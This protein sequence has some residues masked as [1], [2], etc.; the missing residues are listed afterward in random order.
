M[1]RY[2]D[3]G[4]AVNWASPLNRGLVSWWMALP[5]QQRGLYFRD[6]CGRNHGTLTNGP[7]WQGAMGR[8]GGSGAID[9]GG[10]A[11]SQSVVVSSSASLP[12]T[13][14]TVSAWVSAD[15]WETTAGQY[16]GI[17]FRRVAGSNNGW[18]IG[19]NGDSDYVEFTTHDG[20]F[21]SANVGYSAAGLSAGNWN[22]LCGTCDATNVTLYINGVQKAQVAGGITAPSSQDVYIGRNNAD[23]D[24]FDGRIDDVRLWNRALSASEV[25]ALYHASRTG[26]QNELNWRRRTLI[27]DAGGGAPS[28][29]SAWARNANS[30]WTVSAA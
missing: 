14:V 3:I 27:F 18:W 2:V 17:V 5:G 30:V 16:P 1:S 22:L 9:F 29:K 24:T 4:D 10:L 21:R 23:A 8:P 26:Y 28:F 6:L 12:T 13:L 20:T 19:T 7:T 25:S 11:T 15:V